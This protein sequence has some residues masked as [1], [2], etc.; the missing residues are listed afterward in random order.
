M[1]Q[2]KPLLDNKGVAGKKAGEDSPLTLYH[3][4]QKNTPASFEA[5]HDKKFSNVS[6]FILLSMSRIVH[7]YAQQKYPPRQKVGCWNETY[8]IKYLYYTPCRLLCKW[9]EGVSSC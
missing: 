7:L 6:N 1:R 3:I 2:K 9:W 4:S 8:E 5:R